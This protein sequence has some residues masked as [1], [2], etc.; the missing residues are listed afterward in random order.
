MQ[1]YLPERKTLFQEPREKIL[2]NLAY[3]LLFVLLPNYPQN[4]W[5]KQCLTI[6]NNMHILKAS[7]TLSCT[8]MLKWQKILMIDANIFISYYSSPVQ[9]LLLSLPLYPFAPTTSSQ[10]SQSCL[11]PFHLMIV[12]EQ[13]FEM[14]RK[15]LTVSQ[16]IVVQSC[17]IVV[18][19]S[20]E[21]EQGEHINET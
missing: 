20:G 11:N 3:H 17:A 7:I 18:N 12:K 2:Q 15:Y 19:L 8:K 14:L 21:Y 10:T 13:A 6:G 5:L 16:R 1:I 4:W 9:Y